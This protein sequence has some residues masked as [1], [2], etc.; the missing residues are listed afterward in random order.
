YHA[1]DRASARACGVVTVGLD[2]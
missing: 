2:N 1:V